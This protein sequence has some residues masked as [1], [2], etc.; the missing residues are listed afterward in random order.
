MKIFRYLTFACLILC[1]GCVYK[2][3]RY[4]PLADTYVVRQGDTLSS[5]A[6]EVTG[7]TGYWRTLSRANPD[8]NPDRLRPGQV[9]SIPRSIR[10]RARARGPVNRPGTFR[11][12]EP[13]PADANWRDYPPDSSSRGGNVRRIERENDGPGAGEPADNPDLRVVPLSRTPS[14]GGVT[15]LGLGAVN[16]GDDY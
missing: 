15:G 9:I 2:A 8:I 6:F 1:S 3:G 10:T 16:S 5:I 7:D 12:R 13:L 14:S 11:F 4:D